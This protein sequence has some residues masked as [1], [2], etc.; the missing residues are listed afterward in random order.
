MIGVDL[1]DK[2]MLDHPEVYGGRYDRSTA[3]TDS[4]TK[5]SLDLSQGCV[6]GVLC[7]RLH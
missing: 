4:H 2:L 6:N 5:S 7:G 3:L 1:K